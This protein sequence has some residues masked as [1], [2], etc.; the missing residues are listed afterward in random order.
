[1]MLH[2]NYVYI[3]YIPLVTPFSEPSD[4]CTTCATRCLRWKKSRDAMAAA[5]AE[6]EKAGRAR[7][8]RWLDMLAW[9]FPWPWGYPKP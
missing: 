6:K 2:Y 7:A 3:C 4:L 9:G 1:M 5:E 8:V